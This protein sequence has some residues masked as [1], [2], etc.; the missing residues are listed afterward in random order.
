MFV[1]LITYKKPLNVIDEFLIV[2]RAYL[3][4][5]YKN[6]I[7]FASGPQNPRTGGVLLSQLNDRAQ[8]EQFIQN[9]PFKINGLADYQIIEFEPVKCHQDFL[10]FIKHEMN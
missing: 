5:G 3:D 4:E 6:N 7:L 2:H 9:D 10:R 8:L 1:V